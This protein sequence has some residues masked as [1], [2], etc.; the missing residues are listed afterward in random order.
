M[1]PNRSTKI[2]IAIILIL[3]CQT[4]NLKAVTTTLF[5]P[6]QAIQLTTEGTGSDTYTTEGYIITVT[7]DKLFTGGVGMNGRN[8]VVVWPAGLQA[9]GG[10][11]GTKPSGKANLSIKRADGQPFAITAFSMKLLASTTGAGASLEVMPLIQGEDGLTDPVQFDATGYYGFSQSFNTAAQFAGHN[12]DSYK[13]TLY[14]DFAITGITLVDAGAAPVQAPPPPA[15]SVTRTSTTSLK[16][17]WPGDV[18]DYKL[19]TCTDLKLGNWI[20]Q[21][22]IRT[23]EGNTNVVNVVLPV[24]D[25]QRFFR[26]SN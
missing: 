5:N 16:L 25:P 12:Y 15:F 23:I 1:N 6:E 4:G 20:T 11:T 8:P 18:F 10:I 3:L 26:L 7:R 2:S 14:V 13:F 24:T 17:S 9:Q 21:A 22:G 19:Q